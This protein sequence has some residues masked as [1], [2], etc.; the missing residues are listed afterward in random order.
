MTRTHV[1][2]KDRRGLSVG[3]TGNLIAYQD[4]DETLDYT[5]DWSA[6]LGSD[7]ISSVAY[8][9]NGITLTS[10][11]N[12]TTSVTVWTTGTAGELVMTITTTAGRVKQETI[13]FKET[14]A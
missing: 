4:K 14:A 6:W 2:R 12:T 11:S 7:T 3:S 5:I 1:L 9:A 8:T 13:T 10:S